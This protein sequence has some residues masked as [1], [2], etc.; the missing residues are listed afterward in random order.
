M[1]TNKTAVIE[2]G[3]N[4]LPPADRGSIKR[5][6]ENPEQA[7]ICS[8]INE[9]ETKTL[10]EMSSYSLGGLFAMLASSAVLALHQ[11][12]SPLEI[13]VPDTQ[14][15]AQN[16]GC[17]SYEWGEALPYKEFLVDIYKGLKALHPDGQNKKANRVFMSLENIHETPERNRPGAVLE[18]SFRLN[19]DRVEI[20]FH[21]NSYEISRL[22]EKRLHHILRQITENPYM[23][24]KD[25]SLA[26]EYELTLLQ[27]FNPGG[28]PYSDTQV[29][30][31][32]FENQV[33]RT[34]DQ[35]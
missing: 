4:C 6:D 7:I 19:K 18:I 34:P 5:Q 32:L 31:E 2:Q 1:A 28:T 24:I 35:T 22:A 21:S 30:I 9:A 11:S 10:L 14:D 25:I 29:L 15:P 12:L 23:Q 33:R 16:Y 13:I 3:S 27:Q 26:G 20:F 17:L 8:E